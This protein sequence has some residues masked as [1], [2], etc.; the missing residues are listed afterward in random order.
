[1]LAKTERPRRQLGSSLQSLLKVLKPLLPVV[2]G[3][4]MQSQIDRL[5]DRALDLEIAK[6]SHELNAGSAVH[7]DGALDSLREL[8][9]GGSL[10]DVK[11]SPR[12]TYCEMKPWGRAFE[13]QQQRRCT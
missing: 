11:P 7:S 10:C 12:R 2:Y 1:M 9:S 6:E 8:P 13:I 5:A 4:W 3:A